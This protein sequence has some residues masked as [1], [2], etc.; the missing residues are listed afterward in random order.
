MSIFQAQEW[1]SDS[2][3]RVVHEP[4]C[5]VINHGR[6]IRVLD[7]T[8]GYTK[9]VVSSPT[10]GLAEAKCR[11]QRVAIYKLSTTPSSHI[12]VVRTLTQQ[13]IETGVYESMRLIEDLYRLRSRTSFA[14]GKMTT[15]ENKGP[16]GPETGKHPRVDRERDL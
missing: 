12:P 8:Q 3:V 5:L 4:N 13:G 2:I 10:N 6:N 14:S 9:S 11:G 1:T 15:H 16:C 7:E